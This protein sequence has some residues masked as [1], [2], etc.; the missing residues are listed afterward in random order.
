MA[1]PWKYTLDNRTAEEEEEGGGGRG[2]GGTPGGR[3][4]ANI[5]ERRIE[6]SKGER[7]RWIV[8]VVMR[9]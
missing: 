6:E 4:R 8:E 1:K 2:R 3:R 9:A 5:T 7:E